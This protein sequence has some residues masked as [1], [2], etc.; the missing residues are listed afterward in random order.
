MLRCEVDGAMGFSHAPS[1]HTYMVDSLSSWVGISLAPAMPSPAI[2]AKIVGN[3]A[4]RFPWHNFD[5]FVF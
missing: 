4:G 3:G 1:Y 5:V 2:G